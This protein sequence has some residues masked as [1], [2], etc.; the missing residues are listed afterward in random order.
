M[1]KHFKGFGFDQGQSKPTITK[2]KSLAD[3]SADEAS[4]AEEPSAADATAPKHIP[5]KMG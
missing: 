2:Y 5:G 3:L 4:E 1:E